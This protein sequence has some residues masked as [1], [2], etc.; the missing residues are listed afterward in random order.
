MTHVKICCLRAQPHGKLIIDVQV[1]NVYCRANTTANRIDELLAARQQT[2][3]LLDTLNHSIE[4]Y[5]QRQAQVMRLQH[6]RYLS[7]NQLADNAICRRFHRTSS[8]RQAPSINRHARALT[9]DCDNSLSNYCA[10]NS[11][12]F[13]LV[14]GLSIVA[15]A[16]CK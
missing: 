8:Q 1:S 2:L 3:N 11:Y 13:T 16:P 9:G 7:N 15:L 12:T 6:E 14:A 10:E 4:Q 5:E